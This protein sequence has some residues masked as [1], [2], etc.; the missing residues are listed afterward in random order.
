MKNKHIQE[1]WEK[2]LDEK[3]FNK[4]AYIGKS[5]EE[6]IEKL[7]Q[8]IQTTLQE[9]RQR[10]IEEMKE[11]QKDFEKEI[12]RLKDINSPIQRLFISWA[13]FKSSGRG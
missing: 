5:G 11:K 2:E 8:F 13:V 7:K 3:F 12:R 6:H 10:V 4:L 1:N 9:E